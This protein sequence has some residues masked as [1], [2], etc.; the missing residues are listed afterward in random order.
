LVRQAGLVADK[1]DVSGIALVAERRRGLKAA[2][3]GPNHH[4]GAGRA[5]ARASRILIP[6]GPVEP[7]AF[8]AFI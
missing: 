1:D 3:P 2:L 6:R 8:A 7:F 4:D 5:H